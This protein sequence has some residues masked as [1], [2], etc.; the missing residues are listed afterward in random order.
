MSTWAWLFSFNGRI[1]RGR[2]W[3]SL[4]VYFGVGFLIGFAI[5]FAKAFNN[6]QDMGP[7]FL[8]VV[9]V[10]A[11]ALVI[12]SLAVGAKRFHD[13]G[14]TAWLL[15]AAFIISLIGQVIAASSGD[16]QHP[17]PIGLLISLGVSAWLLIDLGIMPGVTG[18]NKYG[19]DPRAEA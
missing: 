10:L 11:I 4:L 17:N 16:L 19:P 8:G 2:Y 1:G 6:T 13:R 12:S 7:I 3:A 9:I 5:G 18:P 14:K 15:L